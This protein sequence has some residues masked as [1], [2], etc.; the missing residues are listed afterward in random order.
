MTLSDLSD[1]CDTCSERATFT[2]RTRVIEGKHYAIL[3]CPSCHADIPV[4]SR[5]NEPLV[6]EWAANPLPEA[7][8]LPLRGTDEAAI[9]AYLASPP[10][11]VP[12][13]RLTDVALPRRAVPHWCQLVLDH[14]GLFPRPTAGD[15]I[16]E[17]LAAALLFNEDGCAEQAAE[18]LSTVSGPEVQAVLVRLPARAG[19]RTGAALRP[20]ISALRAAGGEYSAAVRT[21]EGRWAL[22]GLREGLLPL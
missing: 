19:Q 2:G 6:A 14:P 21:V 8:M 3:R 11:R 22:P 13:W 4:W 5:E 12:C 10:Q 18:L 15:R 9:A 1:T 7:A 17:A 16:E 20:F